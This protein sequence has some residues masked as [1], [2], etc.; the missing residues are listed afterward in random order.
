MLSIQELWCKKL[1]PKGRGGLGYRYHKH[2]TGGAIGDDDWDSSQGSQIDPSTYDTYYDTYSIDSWIPESTVAGYDPYQI[3][4]TPQGRPLY[5]KY[6]PEQMDEFISS[7]DIKRLLNKPMPDELKFDIPE[8]LETEIEIQ[9]DIDYMNKVF[10]DIREEVKK[11]SKVPLYYKNAEVGNR[12]E[13]YLNNHTEL[14]NT[15]QLDNLG[16]TFNSSNADTYYSD[17]TLDI[18][19]DINENIRPDTVKKL[20]DSLSKFINDKNNETSNGNITQ[21]R[22]K[23]LTSL[24]NDTLKDIDKMSR[25]VLDFY[26]VDYI[27]DNNLFEIKALSKKYSQYK[28]T[29][30]ETK[31]FGTKK[32][33]VTYNGKD[34]KIKGGINFVANKITG[35]EGDF[36]P[37]F[38]KKSDGSVVV[39]NINWYHNP[40]KRKESIGTLK[41][42]YD[43][44]TA[45]FFLEDGIY[46]YDILKDDKLKID[47]NGKASLD[48][49]TQSSDYI[50]PIN[51][52]KKVSAK[53]L[54]TF[55][56]PRFTSDTI[57]S[58]ELAN[59]IEPIDLSDL[60]IVSK[61]KNTKKK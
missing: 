30:Y 35:N 5:N 26:L 36:K 10:L 48:Y 42:E 16:E 17:D 53:E 44:Y 18:A 11:D 41:H 37:L 14:F 50:I 31:T 46:K 51:K 2:F 33:S 40:F 15:L 21:E 55:N 57:I 32:V 58:S 60:G 47:K 1:R 61:S 12:V 13:D 23:E 9:E 19:K 8:K 56:I 3:G 28:E 25:P 49:P 27:S 54:L 22:D 39:K 24:I 34:T 45:I 7:R 59:M 29:V 6:T 43:N 20:K 4:I 52:L 38:E